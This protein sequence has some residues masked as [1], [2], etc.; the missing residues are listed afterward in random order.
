MLKPIG[1]RIAIQMIE[2]PD[3]TEGGVFLPDSAKPAS[4]RGTVVAVGPGPWG[5]QAAAAANNATA[6]VSVGDTVV[7]S[8][9]AGHAI[10]EYRIV[11][12]GELIAIVD[13]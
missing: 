10:D 3:K 8:R 4:Q 7:I 12:E 6:P 5:P 13:K 9:H 1:N 11:H 2:E